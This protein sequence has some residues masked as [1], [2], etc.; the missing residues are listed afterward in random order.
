MMNCLLAI[1][2]DPLTTVFAPIVA[3]IVVGLVAYRIAKLNAVQRN[4]NN[5]M[6]LVPLYKARTPLV[7]ALAAFLVITGGCIALAVMDG[8][9]IL[10]GSLAVVSVSVAVL[11]ARMLAVKY[12]VVDN[13]ILVPYA[14]IDWQHLSDY[15]IDMDSYT[16][17]FIADKGGK[18]GLATTSVSLKFNVADAH[19]LEMLLT[20]RKSVI[21]KE[22][23]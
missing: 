17:F 15:E 8:E 10:Y 16:V 20:G 23:R 1:R 19:K 7:L 21:S 4:L 18:K 9:A 12:A 5:S 2:I 14:F 13:G 3:V 6:I 11:V 22:L